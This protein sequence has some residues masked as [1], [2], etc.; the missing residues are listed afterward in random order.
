[1]ITNIHCLM[2]FRSRATG[3]V[4]ESVK[5]SCEDY[6]K[7]QKISEENNLKPC[8]IDYSLFYHDFSACMVVLCKL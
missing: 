5:G 2:T 6:E 1:M 7:H 8:G 4:G 3:D